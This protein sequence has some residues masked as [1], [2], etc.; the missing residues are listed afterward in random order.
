MKRALQFLVVAYAVSVTAQT[1]AAGG[2]GW[3]LIG[4]SWRWGGEIQAET[5]WFFCISMHKKVCLVDIWMS[6]LLKTY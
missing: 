4:G 6:R 5:S 3:G 1:D 2:V